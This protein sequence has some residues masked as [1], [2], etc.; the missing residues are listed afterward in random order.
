MLEIVENIQKLL[1]TR[2]EYQHRAFRLGEEVE[3][4]SARKPAVLV[5]A[6]HGGSYEGM[7]SLRKY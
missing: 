4:A 5:F 6:G 1:G 7:G 3:V 2:P